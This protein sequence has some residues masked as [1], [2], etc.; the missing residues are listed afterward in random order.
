MSSPLVHDK[1]TKTGIQKKTAALPSLVRPR[2]PLFPGRW[3]RR[4]FFSDTDK[5]ASPGDPLAALEKST[6][7]QNHVAKVQ[8]PRLEELQEVS[9]HYGSD[10]YAHSLRVRKRFREEKKVEK[11]KQNAD[12]Q[13][14]GRYGL[15]TSLTLLEDD[16]A[17][18]QEAHE[19]WLREKRRKVGDSSKSNFDTLRARVLANKT[20]H[21]RPFS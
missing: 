4:I 3:N 1:K 20:R 16:A 2:A 15:P 17:S 21:S 6:V 8:A 11:Q 9:Q 5:A 19:Q 13:L 14:K 18:K 12:D 10:P 7:A